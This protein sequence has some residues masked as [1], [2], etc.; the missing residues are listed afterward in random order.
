MGRVVAGTVR[1]L[2][3]LAV[4]VL[5]EE[6]SVLADAIAD[7]FWAGRGL[8]VHAVLSAPVARR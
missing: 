7:A 2:A 6:A 1:Q 4:K 5:A 3:A 8:R